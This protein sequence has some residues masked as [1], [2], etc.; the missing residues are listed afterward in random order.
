MIRTRP[1]CAMLFAALLLVACGDGNPT[2]QPSGSVLS[3]ENA[4]VRPLVA[5]HPVAAAYCDVV[6]RGDA[7]IVITGFTSD[8]PAV[9]AEIHETSEAGGIIRMRPLRRVAVPAKD[10]VSFAP[11]GKH[12]MLFGFDD[13]APQVKLTAMLDDGRTVAAVFSTQPEGILK[14]D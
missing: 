13:T 6:N 3:F 8:D 12:L 10:R 1:R 9:R 7:E 14:S 2:Q 4:R 11:G 5:G